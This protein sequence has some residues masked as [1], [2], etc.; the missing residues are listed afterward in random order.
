M[1]P[2][3]DEMANLLAI[4]AA[5]T[6]PAIEIIALKSQPVIPP[7]ENPNANSPVSIPEPPKVKNKIETMSDENLIPAATEDEAITTEEQAINELPAIPLY[8]PTSYSLVK[9]YIQNFDTNILDA[10][11]LKDVRIDNN[12]QPKTT[13]GESLN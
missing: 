12:W 2:T 9:P 5:P 13:K 4:F 8:F 10:P 3:N 7:D 11:S 1:L 6:K